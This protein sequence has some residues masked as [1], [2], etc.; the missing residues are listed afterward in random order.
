MRQKSSGNA[1]FQSLKSAKGNQRV[2]LLSEP[3]FGMPYNM[4]IPFAAVYMAACG[5]NPLQIGTMA[6]VN[7]LSQM[8]ASTVSGAYSDKLGRR[9][10]LILFDIISWCAPMLVWSFWTTYTGFFVA[11][12]LNG[13]WRP[14]NISYSMLLS[15]DADPKNLVHYYSLT[16]IA[17]LL[18]GFFTPL[19]FI[20]VKR[21][22]TIPAVR[23][24]CL[25]MCFTIALKAYIIHKYC[26]DT[27]EAKDKMAEFKDVPIRHIVFGS[28]KLF[29]DMFRTP[30]IMQAA[31]IM[32]CYM[33]IKNITEN[34]WP[35]YVTGL[36]GQS[37]EQLSLFS[38]LK[39]LV[40]L[41]S[42][43]VILPKVRIDRFHYPAVKAFLIY[44]LVNITYV[45]L[46]V[47]GLPLVIFGSALEGLSLSIIIPLTSSILLTALPESNKAQ[48]LSHSYTLCLLVSSP[49]GVFAG[50]LSSI[51]LSFP[52]IL[53]AV[54]A[55]IAIVL[56][57]KLHDNLFPERSDV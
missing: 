15:E 36:V 20:L 51:N 49:M 22:G 38:T 47:L 19:S 42:T 30:Q 40:M 16:N 45:L 17:A 1:L 23:A 4:Y 26:Y 25:T 13:W 48:L 32:A 29:K 6:T 57:M 3:L 50:K 37:N 5:L 9:K 33:I 31:G 56:S 18:A 34:F 28:L 43:L 35:L 10:T 21:F 55:A 11:A 7:L 53:G 41:V 27:Q 46:P 14:S 54:I 12:I 52:L 44:I 8:V 24:I 39:T 2:I